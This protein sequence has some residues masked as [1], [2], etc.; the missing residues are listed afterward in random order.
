MFVWISL[1]ALMELSL[2]MVKAH[3]KSYCCLAFHYFLLLLLFFSNQ[4]FLSSYNESPFSLCFW[5]LPR[6]ILHSWHHKN[7]CKIYVYKEHHLKVFCCKT[8]FEE[9][10]FWK[11]EENYW[12]CYPPCVRENNQKV[13]LKWNS[14]YFNFSSFPLCPPVTQSDS[15]QSNWLQSN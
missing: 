2:K 11:E 6:Y 9:Q 1:T 4:C 15:P 8:H 12:W 10:T 7:C 14:L 3:S 13:H 5:T